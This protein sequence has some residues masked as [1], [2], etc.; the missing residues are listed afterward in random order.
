MHT[1][2]LINLLNWCTY[3]WKFPNYFSSRIQLDQY[4]DGDFHKCQLFAFTSS[5]L[6]LC[7]SLSHEYESNEISTILRKNI[8]Q[9]K[10]LWLK[11]KVIYMK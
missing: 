8:P 4:F 3:V 2:F 10:W 9:N 5:F 6:L 7:I 11:G 1:A